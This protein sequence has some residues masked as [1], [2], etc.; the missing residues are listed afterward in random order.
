VLRILNS[1]KRLL[2][3]DI[4]QMTDLRSRIPLNMQLVAIKGGTHLKKGVPDLAIMM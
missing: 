2:P 3:R 1:F 4:V